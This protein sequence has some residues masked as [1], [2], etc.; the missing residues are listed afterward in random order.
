MN[1]IGIPVLIIVEVLEI[2]KNIAMYLVGNHKSCIET[3]SILN[4]LKYVRI[5]NPCCL[6][7]E[8][9]IAYTWYVINT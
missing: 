4:C 8:I 5:V 1:F 6:I 3:S 9:H 7:Q 2:T